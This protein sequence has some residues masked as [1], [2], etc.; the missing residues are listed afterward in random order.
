MIATD[1]TVEKI[2]YQAKQLPAQERV[3]IIQLLVETLVTSEKQPKPNL[4]QYGAFHGKR[5]STEE[6]FKIAEWHPTDEELDG[7]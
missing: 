2:V 6:D 1:L 4:W 3:Q 5:M 7:P